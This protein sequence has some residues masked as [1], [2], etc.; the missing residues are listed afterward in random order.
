MGD[1]VLTRT[2]TSCTQATGPLYSELLSDIDTLVATDS[3][4][5]LGHW[6]KMAR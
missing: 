3:A 2:L 1:V 6:L 4:F 5:S